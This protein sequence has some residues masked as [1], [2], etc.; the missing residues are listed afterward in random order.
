[1]FRPASVFLLCLVWSAASIATAQQPLLAPGAVVR[2]VDAPTGSNVQGSVRAIDGDSIIVMTTVPARS[3]DLS[4]SAT[5]SLEIRD[6]HPSAGAHTL[7]GLAIGAGT[8]ILFGLMV[9]QDCSEPGSGWF[10]FSRGD[11][12]KA[13]GVLFGGIGTLAGYLSTPQWR[14]VPAT[15]VTLS[16]RNVAIAPLVTWRRGA[17]LGVTVRF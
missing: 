10:C 7:A 15:G 6:G 12:A 9:G 16:G 13:F 4:I 17:V 3:F 1:M 14:W 2:W 8:G 5:R 11:M